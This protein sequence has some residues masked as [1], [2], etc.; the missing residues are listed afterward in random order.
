M[1]SC[2]SSSSS[3]HDGQL[4]SSP[5]P[6]K[7]TAAFVG[8]NFPDFIE[9]WSRDTFRKVGYGLGAGTGAL[10]LSAGLLDASFF[11]P[12]AIVGGLLTTAYWRIGLNDIRQ[13]GHAIRRNYPLLG[14]MRYVLETIRPEIRQYLVESD[15]DG[16][17]YDRMRR[18][19]IYQRAKNVDDTMAFGTR[20]DVYAT[21]YEWACHSMW[22]KTVCLDEG[23]R[24]TIGNSDFGTTKPYSASVLNI[25]AMS[26]GAI[27]D[28]AILALSRG[29]KMG[30]FYH[31][32]GEG[33][34]SKSHKAGGGD[35][36]WNV[37]KSMVL[38]L[39]IFLSLFLMFL[40]AIL[41]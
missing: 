23:A 10:L 36:V 26:Y 4:P 41:Q 24:C 22:P 29:A 3:N 33:G 38:E 16:K 35:L 40:F 31:N 37:G 2:F 15:Q 19:L 34:V 27:S 8:H 17:P 32:T 21:N 30:N 11:G 1:V 7:K 25:S 9:Y 5:N 6:A 18:S 28:N 14:N 12:P 39:Y 20:R 13:T